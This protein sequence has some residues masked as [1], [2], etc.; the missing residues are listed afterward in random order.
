VDG[1]G[2]TPSCASSALVKA[3]PPNVDNFPVTTRVGA[4]LGV[5]KQPSAGRTPAVI[6]RL[7]RNLFGRPPIGWRTHR[8]LRRT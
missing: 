8:E 3:A 6:R 1:L 5:S 2:T 7:D 4:F